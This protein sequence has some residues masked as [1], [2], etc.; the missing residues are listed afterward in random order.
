M[1][2]YYE[3]N[4][5][6]FKAWSGAVDTLDAIK[7]AGKTEE[8]ENLMIEFFPEGSDET[9]I[10]DLLWFDSEMILDSLGIRTY[11]DIEDEMK[12]VEEEINNLKDD[13]ADDIEGLSEDDANDLYEDNYKN[14][15]EELQDRLNEL[16]EELEEV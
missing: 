10:N 4:M 8:L 2:I 11:E 3:T 5:E 15:I 1:K 6:D 14:D 16:S 12:Q 7:R 13:Y 9:A